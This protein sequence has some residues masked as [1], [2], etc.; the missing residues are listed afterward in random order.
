MPMKL[1]P[2]SWPSRSTSMCTG[3]DQVLAMKAAKQAPLPSTMRSVF[4]AQ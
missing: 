4:S 3:T 1:P 2:S